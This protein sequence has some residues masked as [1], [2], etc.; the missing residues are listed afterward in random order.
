MKISLI[1]LFLLKMSIGFG[2][3]K[4]NSKLYQTTLSVLLSHSV[5]EITVE[6]A[7][8]KTDE[9]LFLDA[10]KFDEY[11]V[12][13]IHKAKY[14][15]YKDFTLDSLQN[16]SKSKEII[17]YCSVGYRSEK[18]AK[19]IIESGFTNV[20]NM[21]GGLFEWVNQKGEIENSIQVTDSVHAYNT[22]WGK[23]ITNR[24]IQKVYK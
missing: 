24:N 2:Q 21:Y 9:V 3:Q 23:W 15:G 17:V 19:K 12:S 7:M 11:Q 13:H 20:S 8:K 5:P 22:I 6:E 18:I 10:R 4:V 16:I 1:L 14:V